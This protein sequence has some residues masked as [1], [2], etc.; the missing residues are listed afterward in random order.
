[1]AKVL[2][3]VTARL[4]KSAIKDEANYS[5]YLF[6][7][8]I[9]WLDYRGKQV[10]LNKGDEFGIRSSSDGKKIRLIIKRL[11]PNKVFTITPRDE[12]DLKVRS[13]PITD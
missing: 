4:E 9:A 6:R 10:E 8:Q 3:Q 5:W 7:G 11:G 13:K 12:K 2:K 1:M